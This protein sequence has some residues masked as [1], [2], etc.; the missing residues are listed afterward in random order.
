MSLNEG[1]LCLG[2]SHNINKELLY[3][4]VI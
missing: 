1:I 4:T 2:V 3:G